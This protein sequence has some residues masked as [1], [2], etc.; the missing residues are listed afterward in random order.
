MY[1]V[2]DITLEAA[3]ELSMLKKHNGNLSAFLSKCPREAT[4]EHQGFHFS[5]RARAS[6]SWQVF[7][8]TQS[9]ILYFKRDTIIL[10]G[11]AYTMFLIKGMI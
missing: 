10:P 9:W 7:G 3:M 5:A 4:T 8:K 11:E 1:M 2:G 6:G